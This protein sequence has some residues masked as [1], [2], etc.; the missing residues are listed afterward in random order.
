M[1]YIF[2]CRKSKWSFKDNASKRRVEQE[3][4]YHSKEKQNLLIC[5]RS[6]SISYEEL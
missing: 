1:D 6:Y 3:I 2:N 5:V 4:K